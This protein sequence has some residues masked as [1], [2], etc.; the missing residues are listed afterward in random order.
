[1]DKQQ[2]ES[3]VSRS[4]M[5]CSL[6]WLGM[7]VTWTFRSS[8][9]GGVFG[10]VTLV[11]ALISFSQIR[12][13]AD[14]FL[15]LSCA[16]WVL[17]DETWLLS[18]FRPEIQDYHIPAIMAAS[19]VLALI[20]SLGLYVRDQIAKKTSADYTGVINCLTWLLMDVSWM[21]NFQMATLFFGLATLVSGCIAVLRSENVSERLVNASMLCWIILNL[22]AL[23]TGM[24]T[25]PEVTAFSN[26]ISMLLVIALLMAGMIVAKFDPS[27]AAIFRKARL[28]AH[29]RVIDTTS[30]MPPSEMDIVITHTGE[31]S[32]IRVEGR[33]DSLTA[34]RFQKAVLDEVGKGARTIRMDASGVSYISSMGLR[35]LL[36]CHKHLSS[37]GGSFK[38]DKISSQAMQIIFMAGMDVIVEKQ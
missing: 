16:L 11:A 2:A 12:K 8:V 15:Y 36:I 25:M 4:D 6:A 5:I 31:R 35:A 21:M 29:K 22:S 24:G 9:A 17:M 26:P 7:D 13:A 1:M 14:W 32:D 23:A 27:I 37:H 19:A 38:I 30:V 34:D 33:I 18:E 3:L 20:V 10:L 28:S